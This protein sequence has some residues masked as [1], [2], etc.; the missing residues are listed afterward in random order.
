[1]TALGASSSSPDSLTEDNLLP[2]YCPWLTVHDFLKGRA[3][4]CTPCLS[5]LPVFPEYIADI[6]E[7]S[8]KNNGGHLTRRKQASVGWSQAHGRDA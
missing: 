3:T 6:Q 1:M 2:V 7:I 4:Y 5:P 8:A